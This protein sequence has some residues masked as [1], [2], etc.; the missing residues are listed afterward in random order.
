ALPRPHLRRGSGPGAP[1]GPSRAAARRRSGA[2]DPARTPPLRDR[3]ELQPDRRRLHPGRAAPPVRQRRAARVV[4]R[5]DLARAQ[6][7][8]LRG[9]DRVRPAPRTAPRRAWSCHRGPGRPH[10]Q[11]EVQAMSSASRP[12]PRSYLT[13]ALRERILFLDGAMGTAL[14]AYHLDEAAYRGERFASHARDLKGNHDVLVLTRPDVVREVHDA[15]L[16]A[17]ADLIET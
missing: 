8:V 17:G 3:S 2:G 9:R 4:L 10:E 14:Q 6:E 1:R 13:T 15:Y 12:D 5:R 11:Q 7:A 16:A